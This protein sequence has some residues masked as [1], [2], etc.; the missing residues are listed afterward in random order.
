MIKTRCRIAYDRIVEMGDSDVDED[1]LDLTEELSQVSAELYDILCQVCRGDAR[2]LL[3][4]ADDLNGFKAWQTLY[5]GSNSR[6]VARMIKMLAQVTG[7][8]RRRT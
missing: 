5:R 2:T 8:V 4:T 1:L 7:L 6:T 3:M